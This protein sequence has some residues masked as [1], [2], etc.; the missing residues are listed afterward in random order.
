MRANSFDEWSP[1]RE[2]IVGTAGGYEK[3]DMDLSFRLFFN[4]VANSSFYYPSLEARSSLE[5]ADSRRP[6][7]SKY[8][9]ELTEDLEELAGALSSAG[10]VVHRP[11]S[12]DGRSAFTTPDWAS[13]MIPA[14]NVRDQT[15]VLGDEIIET[16][17][18]VRARL[19]ES[20]LLK[21]IFRRYFRQ[22]SRWTTMPRPRLLDRSF[23][24]S[25]VSGQATP[26]I[27]DVGE[28]GGT[29]F[30]FEIMIDGAQCI[31]LGRDLLINV[32]TANHA[33]GAQWLTRHLEGRFRVHVMERFADNHID[34]L[35]LPLRPGLLLLRN[36]G[37]AE[38]LPAPLQK[39]DRIYAP[40]PLSQNFPS[41]DDDDLI[42]SSPYIDMNV[43]SL[44]RNTVVVNS[45]F[46]ELAIELEKHGID[47]VPV[48]HRHR[49]LFGGGFHCFTLDVVREGGDESYFKD[50]EWST[51]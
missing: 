47:V 19:T 50:T 49:R 26:A 9:E 1:L 37:V 38:H 35:V 42:V 25:Y 30:D 24:T 22:G 8:V 44:D 5:A 20:D 51:P 41:Y 33:L 2:V 27:E 23:D 32:A 28:S 34:S 18:Q 14:L 45:L 21:P 17:P 3:H 7:N 15:I 36:P 29:D 39:W 16:S 11:D 13:T 46:P 43:L 31:R 4:D 6:L 10:I 48:R 40:I 12:L